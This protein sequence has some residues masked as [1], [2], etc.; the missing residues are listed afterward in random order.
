MQSSAAAPPPPSP[1]RPSSAP[2]PQ[3]ESYLTRVGRRCYPMACAAFP[4]E[5]D[6]SHRILSQ[7]VAVPPDQQ[8]QLD[9]LMRE[10][11]P[12]SGAPA[13]TAAAPSACRLSPSRQRSTGATA[14]ARHRRRFPRQQVVRTALRLYGLRPRTVLGLSVYRVQTLRQYTE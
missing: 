8:R 7:M 3:E 14:R 12:E 10:L 4:V 9:A 11:V 5:A 6:G 13:P 1:R 2:A